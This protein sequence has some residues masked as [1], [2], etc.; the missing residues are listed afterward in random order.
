[1][2]D[3]IY[4]PRVMPEAPAAM[5]LP[6][7]ED[8]GAGVGQ[9]LGQAG[10]VVNE[11]ALRQFTQERQLN[12]NRELA[13][14]GVQSA[15]A[16][17]NMDEVA[18]QARLDNTDPDYTNH[19]ANMQDFLDQQGA[20][21]TSGIKE[22]AVQRHAQ[23]DWT[24]FSQQFLGREGDYVAGQQAANFGL[25]NTHAIQVKANTV[26]N[27]PDPE[28]A[29]NEALT[30]SDAQIQAGN[31]D[32]LTKKKQAQEAYQQIYSA[33]L[34]RIIMG[35]AGADGQQLTPPNPAAA[36]K[37]IDSGALAGSGLTSEQLEAKR[38]LALTEFR[39][40]QEALLAADAQA[41]A[42]LADDV[43]AYR[44][45][46]KGG[47][48]VN[49]A[50]GM[51]LRQRALGLKI[52][53][54]GLAQ[55]LTND[56]RDNHWHNANLNTAPPDLQ[57]RLNTLNAKPN[58]TD[59]DLAEIKYLNGS[60]PGQSAG[61]ENDTAGWIQKHGT[62]GALPPPIDPANLT[63]QALNDR[64]AWQRVQSNVYKR[65]VPMFTRTEADQLKS[66]AAQS[67]LGEYALAQQLSQLDGRLAENTAKYIEPDNHFLAQLVHAPTRVI[68]MVGEG[69][70]A[71]SEFPE[72]VDVGQNKQDANDAFVQHIGRALDLMPT[73]QSKATLEIAKS[74]YA[75][76][77]RQNG[78]PAMDADNFTPFIDAA[79]GRHFADWPTGARVAMPAG[80]DEPSFINKINAYTPS[81]T[82][83]APYFP[84][85]Q[86]MTGD[87]LRQ[88]TPRL[89]PD[90]NYRF[91][92]PGNTAVLQKDQ[93]H[94]FEW[95]PGS[96]PPKPQARR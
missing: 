83:L 12:E 55:E 48:A 68:G 71:R 74:L 10:D 58:K 59:D 86:P 41:K 65:D 2:A 96:P 34:D 11:A 43:Q 21:L 6:T 31:V 36:L 82:A 1:M 87:Q 49:D 15:I 81:Q 7:P 29:L 61:F 25:N 46:L 53:D 9:A 50:E 60:L 79:A 24:N 89:L 38:N 84:N 45:K 32:V 54:N 93:R 5:P 40:Q 23:Q 14:Y 73:E 33:Y 28:T 57:A 72:I 52:P 91:V 44:A 77:A 42:K 18:R 37:S 39:R 35:T 75:R 63:P 8:Y 90:G 4:Q 94:Y 80:F 26:R 64:A 76:W 92:G 17:Q 70:A 22:G 56:I 85:G 67:P 27:S 30:S 66:N 19:V 51:A 47:D 78:N 20:D 62:P 95:V 69:H 16:K 3:D 88:F 13:N